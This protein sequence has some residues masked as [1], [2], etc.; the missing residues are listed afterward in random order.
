M[1]GETVGREMMDIIECL[2]GQEK[3]SEV[4]AMSVEYQNRGDVRIR[5]YGP[6]PSG[7]STEARLKRQATMKARK[8]LNLRTD[9]LDD[10]HWQDLAREAGFR[11]PVWSTPCTPGTMTRWLKRCGLSVAW[12]REATGFDSLRQ[13]INANPRWPLRAW[14]GLCLEER[15]ASLAPLGVSK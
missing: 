3:T 11:L 10:P 15:E 2:S 12:Y 7:L 4:N 13:H 1:M 9:F 5:R 6:L 14:V 8:A